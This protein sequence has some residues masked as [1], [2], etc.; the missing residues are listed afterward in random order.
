M[1]EPDLSADKV[2]AHPAEGVVP[3]SRQKRTGAQEGVDPTNKKRRAVRNPDAVTGLKKAATATKAKWS[4]TFMMAESLKR[5]INNNPDWS[6]AKGECIYK[7]FTE[8]MD[9]AGWKRTEGRLN[10]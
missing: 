3:R 9:E 4:R 8:R 10:M 6:W 7:P 2:P 5:E 1:K